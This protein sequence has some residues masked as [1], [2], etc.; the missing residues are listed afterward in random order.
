MPFTRNVQELEV[1]PTF[2]TGLS[3]FI[4]INHWQGFF[5]E[6]IGQF[7]LKEI[8]Q[9]QHSPFNKFNILQFT[10]KVLKAKFL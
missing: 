8:I 2:V 3:N 10:K 4:F 6:F 9:L 7:S 1:S 5:G